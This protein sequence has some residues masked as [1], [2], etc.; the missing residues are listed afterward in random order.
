MPR[1][2]FQYHFLDWPDH[3]VPDPSHLLHMMQRIDD[4]SRQLE[5]QDSEELLTDTS[6][7]GAFVTQPTLVVQKFSHLSRDIFSFVI[8]FKFAHHCLSRAGNSSDNET[9]SDSEAQPEGRLRSPLLVH[10]S[11]GIGRTGAFIIIHTVLH[12]LR[13][14]G[15]LV[16]DVDMFV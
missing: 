3:G 6:S 12:K 7:S 15:K 5:E 11:A 2:V 10:C 1:T 8:H 14:E 4:H 13:E 9:E 16:N